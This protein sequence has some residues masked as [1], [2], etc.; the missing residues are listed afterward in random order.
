MRAR[1]VF[2]RNELLEHLV[3]HKARFALCGAGIA[4]PTELARNLVQLVCQRREA[5]M[6]KPSKKRLL[7]KVLKVSAKLM[8]LRDSLEQLDQD[9]RRMRAQ[10]ELV[11]K[12]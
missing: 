4:S 5:T 6:E 7:R 1:G 9:I 8:Q 12:A 11:S 10:R 2:P 3:E